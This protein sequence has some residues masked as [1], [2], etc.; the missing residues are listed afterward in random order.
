M[1][2]AVYSFTSSYAQI[3]GQKCLGDPGQSTSGFDLRAFFITNAQDQQGKQLTRQDSVSFD[4]LYFMQKRAL[5]GAA[6]QAH[7]AG[8]PLTSRLA[9]CSMTFHVI[10]QMPGFGQC[11]FYLFHRQA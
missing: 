10:H 8:W 5:D 9:I 1:K 2:T 6:C 4:S 3:I 11:R 7:I